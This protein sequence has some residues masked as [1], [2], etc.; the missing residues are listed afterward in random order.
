MS[1]DQS[2]PQPA[3]SPQPGLETRH[4]TR[5]P[6]VI[7]TKKMKKPVQRQYAEF[8]LQWMPG[9]ARLAPRHAHRDDHVAQTIALIRRKRQDIRHPVPA[10]VSTIEL[11]DAAVWNDRDDDD[12]PRAR[13]CDGLKPHPEARDADVARFDDLNDQGPAGH[14]C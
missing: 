9:G 1:L 10:A 13:R 2:L 11:A 8:S 7:I 4:F 3:D 6:L 5:V 14:R 12:A